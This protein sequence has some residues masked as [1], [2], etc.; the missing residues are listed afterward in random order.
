M[1]AITEVLSR[2]DLFK[3]LSDD[4]LAKVEAMAQSVLYEAGAY[5][6]IEGSTPSNMFVIEDGRVAMD[7]SLSPTPGVGKQVTVDTL[8]RGQTCGFSAIR[9]NPYIT[10]ARCTEPVRVITINGQQLR[11]LLDNDPPVGYKVMENM[12]GVVSSRLRNI[13]QTLRMFHR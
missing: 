2:S 13:R 8:G 12:A 10:T 6:F 7:M 5:L 9:G 11:E 4:G 1:P 3:G